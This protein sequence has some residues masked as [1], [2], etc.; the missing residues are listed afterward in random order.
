MI[1]TGIT[2]EH[3]RKALWD[4]DLKLVERRFADSTRYDLVVDG[5]RYPP[6]AIVRLAARYVT[7]QPL[8]SMAAA[9]TS[10]RSRLSSATSDAI[11]RMLR[12]R[13][14]AGVHS[15]HLHD[16]HHEYDS[17]VNHDHDVG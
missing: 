17:G 2:A 13:A 15:D 4:F 3:V 11:F 14:S 6:K 12:D 10:L 9:P 16:N 8:T 5:R 1:P 7:G